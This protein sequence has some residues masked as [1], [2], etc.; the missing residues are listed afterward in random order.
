MFGNIVASSRTT[1]TKANSDLT[2]AYLDELRM[3]RRLS[4]NTIES[5][6]RDLVVLQRFAD[7]G[8]TRFESMSREDLEA[9]VRELMAAGLSPRSVARRVACVRGFFKFLVRDGTRTQ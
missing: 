8:P 3:A 1:D 4:P 2:E 6:A 9:F 7:A 5:Y